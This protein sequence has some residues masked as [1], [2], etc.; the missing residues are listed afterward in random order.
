MERKQES[1]ENEKKN[2]LKSTLGTHLAKKNELKSTLRT[3]LAINFPSKI[4]GKN[5][6]VHT[7]YYYLTNIFSK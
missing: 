5:W 4:W 3:H 6:I 7:I 1:L 2:E